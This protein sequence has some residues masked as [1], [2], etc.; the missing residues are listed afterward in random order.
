MSNAQEL[1]AETNLQQLKNQ[2]KDL[3]KDYQVDKK[4]ACDQFINYHP[5]DVA[6][7]DA[8]LSDAQLV[9]ARVYG[10]SSWPK[11]SEEIESRNIKATLIEHIRAN[12]IEAVKSFIL[13]HPHILNEHLSRHWGPPMSHAANLGH[14]NIIKM[15]SDLGAK[16]YQY[17]FD[18]ACLQGQLETAKWLLDQGAE[19]KE[20][21]VLGPCETLNPEGLQFLVDLGDELARKDGNRLSP[22]A[23]LLEIYTRNPDGKHRCLEICSQQGIEFPDTPMMAFHRGRLDLLEE[24]IKRDSQFIHHRFSYEEI[25]P[26]ELGCGSK[27]Q[28]HGLHGTPID[29][30]TMLHIAI[31]FDEEEVFQW[32]L[33]K[34]ADVNARAEVDSEGFGKHTPIFNTV[35]SNGALCGRQKDGAM[36]KQLLKR[37]ADPNA[38]A[39]IRKRH[40]FSKDSSWHEYHD[41]TPACYANIYS[42]QEWVCQAALKAVIDHGGKE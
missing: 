33:E 36:A 16:D 17:A 12:D 7:K 41:V 6:S 4:K 35:V 5:R 34:G 28:G 27:E 29:G 11:L 40:L 8:K 15:L 1:P 25:Y 2:A 38:R 26:P 30:A 21:T 20:D 19:V 9:I 32:L 24:W 23:K 13:Q 39:N 18:R 10:F 37:G 14:L 3:L 22:V 42:H 31:D